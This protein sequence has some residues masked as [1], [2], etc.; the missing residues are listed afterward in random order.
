[1]K[2]GL[3]KS[4]NDVAGVDLY[5]YRDTPYYNKYDYRLRVSMPGLR[6]TYWC[7][8]PDELDYNLNNPANNYFKV[9]TADIPAVTKNLVSLKEVIS[10]VNGRTKNSNYSCRLES[11]VLAIFAN[12]LSVIDALKTRIGQEYA[13][14]CTY[15]KINGFSGVRYFVNEPKHKYRVYLRSKRVEDD[16]VTEFRDMVSKQKTLYPSPALKRWLNHTKKRVTWNFK[17][18]SSAHFIDYDDESTLT[19]LSLMHGT[20]LGKKYKLEKRPDKT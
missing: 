13:L 18:T 7:K 17:W 8:T 5:E 10:I 12:D 16:F 11:N 6:Y 19:Y 3:L 15:A 14:D 2:M 1:M 9:K 20:M 4:V